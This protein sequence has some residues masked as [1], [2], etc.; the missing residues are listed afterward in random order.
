VNPASAIP[1]RSRSSNWFI[2]LLRDRFVQLGIAIWVL[3]SAAIPFL[4]RGTIPFDRPMVAGLS[5]RAQVIAEIVSPSFSFLVSAVAWLLTRR[6][7][8]PDIAARAPERSVALRETV[9]ALAYGAVV[10]AAGCFIGRLFENHAIASHLT[11][12]MFGLTDM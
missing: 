3:F 6:R 10:L 11:G 1:P 7:I 2:G 4:A 5:Y 12:S 9:G 8:V